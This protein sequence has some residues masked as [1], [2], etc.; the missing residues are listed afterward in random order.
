MLSPHAVSFAGKRLNR[1]LLLPSRRRVR[2]ACSH[3][4]SLPPGSLHKDFSIR[5]LSICERRWRKRALREHTGCK[6]GTTKTTALSVAPLRT[7]GISAPR[8]TEGKSNGCVVDR[9]KPWLG[10]PTRKQRL[11]LESRPL[12]SIRQGKDGTCHGMKPASASLGRHYQFKET[13]ICR[14][15]QKQLTAGHIH[16]QTHM[17]TLKHVEEFVDPEDLMV[18]RRGG[19][20]TLAPSDIGHLYTM[21]LQIHRRTPKPYK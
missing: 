15:S 17:Y 19:H 11:S 10:V 7:Q 6:G 2:D 9:S 5:G 21:L 16:S 20:V 13:Y 1:M 8:S 4:I 14:L 12:L 3:F 18:V